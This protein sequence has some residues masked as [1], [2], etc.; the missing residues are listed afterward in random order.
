MQTAIVGFPP[1]SSAT[2]SGSNRRTSIAPNVASRHAQGAVPEGWS[3]RCSGAVGAHY[4]TLLKARRD[5]RL[6][7]EHVPP[8]LLA[9]H[10][11]VVRRRP[12]GLAHPVP[13]TPPPA[14]L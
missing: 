13:V 4:E 8:Y 7:G 9:H 11:R 5:A 3:E 10:P 6:Q 2:P 12:K 1:L 14:V